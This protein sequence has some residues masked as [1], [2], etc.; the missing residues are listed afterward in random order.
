MDWPGHI[1][2]LAFHRMTDA[3][4]FR[5]FFGPYA[6]PRFC[7]G[8]IVSCAVRGEVVIVGSSFPS[9]SLENNEKQIEQYLACGATTF[10]STAVALA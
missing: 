5:L 3:D 9:H 8:Q 1:R 6:A 2:F 7:N 10:A 4:R